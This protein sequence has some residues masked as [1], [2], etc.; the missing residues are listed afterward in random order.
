MRLPIY[1]STQLFDDAFQEIFGVRPK[2][3][4]PPELPELTPEQ[5]AEGDLTEE[6]R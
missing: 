1:S 5:M 6:R 4:T 2:C 3:V